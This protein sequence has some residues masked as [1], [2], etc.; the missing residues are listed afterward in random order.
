VPGEDCIE[1]MKKKRDKSSHPWR[2]DQVF[3]SDRV[4][5]AIAARGRHRSTDDFTEDEFHCPTTP[6]EDTLWDPESD[7]DTVAGILSGSIGVED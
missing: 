6:E 3:L 4:R 7:R 1:Q 2:K 5:A